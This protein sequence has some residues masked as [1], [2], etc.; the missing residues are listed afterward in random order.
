MISTEPLPILLSKDLNK[1]LLNI[2]FI[3]RGATKNGWN[4]VE[5][6]ETFQ[7]RLLSQNWEVRDRNFL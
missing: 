7:S 4:M 2:E 5:L 1:S 3:V 6:N